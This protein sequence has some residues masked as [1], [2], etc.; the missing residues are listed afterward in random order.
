MEGATT[1]MASLRTHIW[2]LGSGRLFLSPCGSFATVGPSCCAMAGLSSSFGTGECFTSSSSAH[3]Q[4]DTTAIWEY[5]LREGTF[6]SFARFTCWQIASSSS[7]RVSKAFS[8]VAG[9][10]DT[11]LRTRCLGLVLPCEGLQTR[12][13]GCHMDVRNLACEVIVMEWLTFSR[14][15][16]A[17]KGR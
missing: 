7:S 10:D 8:P 14:D 2:T 15:A 5:H 4:P 12:S 9:T 17:T 13:S 11:M 1:A 6:C 16:V 3:R